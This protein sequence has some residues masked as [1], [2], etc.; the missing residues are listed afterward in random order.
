MLDKAGQGHW[1][2]LGALDLE[3][4]ELGRQLSAE[5]L[6]NDPDLS[7]SLGECLELDAE[8]LDLC[9][10]ARDQLAQE[11]RSVYQGIRIQDT[12][13]NSN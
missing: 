2:D 4:M 3:R 9:A 5:A 6:Q 8:I 7:P 1:A 11:L 12:Y 10:N 13:G